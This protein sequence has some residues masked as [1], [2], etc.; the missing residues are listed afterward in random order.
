ML[1]D[2]RYAL[3]QILKNPGFTAVAALT[4]ALG[5]GVNTTMFS[6]LNA[7]VLRAS[8]APDSCRLVSI[9]HTAAQAQDWPQSPA[10]FYDYEHQNT[11]FEQVAGFCQTNFN[12]AEPGQPAER[13][14]ASGVLFLPVSGKSASRNWSWILGRQFAA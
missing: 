1:S 6:V 9:F 7:L 13:L 2:L 5:I 10:D 11:A 8:S 4:L 14:F 3:R 12:L